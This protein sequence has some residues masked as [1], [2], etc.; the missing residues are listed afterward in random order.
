MNRSAQEY[1]ELFLLNPV[2]DC[3]NLLAFLQ[4]DDSTMLLQHLA[5]RPVII[6][7]PTWQV[8]FSGETDVLAA[9]EALKKWTKREP[10][11]A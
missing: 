10:V 9:V 5:H 1:Y 11:R 3:E 4:S 6:E 8:A 7:Y 2:N